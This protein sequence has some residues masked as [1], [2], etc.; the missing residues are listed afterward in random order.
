MVVQPA[1]SAASSGSATITFDCFMS[2]LLFV[3]GEHNCRRYQEY[4]VGG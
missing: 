1:A 4:K 2:L 3:S